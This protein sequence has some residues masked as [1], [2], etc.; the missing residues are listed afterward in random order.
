MIGNKTWL[1]I[2]VMGLVVIPSLA[3][4]ATG[5]DF[6]MDKIEGIWLTKSNQTTNQID[7]DNLNPEI[8]FEDSFANNAAGWVFSLSSINN[9]LAGFPSQYLEEGDSNTGLYISS[10]GRDFTYS[11]SVSGISHAYKTFQIPEGVD[12][13]NISF[14]WIA[15]GY[16]IFDATTSSFIQKDYMKV[17]LVPAAYTP[18]ADQ[19]ITVENSQGIHIGN[20]YYSQNEWILR[21][22]AIHV[23]LGALADQEVKIVFEWVTHGEGSGRVPVAVRQLVIHDITCR[24]VEQF[25]FL[26]NFSA[27]STTRDCWTILDANEDDFT[28]K[29]K[30]VEVYD[31]NTQTYVQ[32]TVASIETDGRNGANDDW[33]IS[34]TFRLSG[35]QRLRYSYR[36]HSSLHPNDFRVVFSTSGRDM[37]NF[38]NT[39]V[40]LTTYNNETYQEEILEL[41]GENGAMFTGDITFAWHV[42]SGGSEGWELMIRDVVVEDIPLC[43]LPEEIAVTTT[44]MD[45]AEVHW[46]TEMD[47]HEAEVAVQ[48]ANSGIPTQ[49]ER[50]THADYTANG[51]ISNTA[52]EVYIRSICM[53]NGVEIYSEWVG[54]VLFRTP[55]EPV[56]LPYVEDFEDNPIWGVSNDTTNQWVIGSAVHNGGTKALYIS[57]NQGEDNQY[58]IDLAQVSHYYKDIMIPSTAID[59]EVVLDWR[60]VG[61][62]GSDDFRIWLVPI[63]FTPEAGQRITVSN[64]R[65]IQLDRNQFYD[66]E[67]FSTVVIEREVTRYAGQTMRL[68]LEWKNNGGVGNQPPAAIDNL[69]LQ[70]T[71]C[72]KPTRVTVNQITQNTAEIAWRNA[73]D[74]E[75]Y[76]IYVT[77]NALEPNEA[78]VPTYAGVTNPYTVQNLLPNTRYYVW[79][80]SA[81]SATN[82]S[83]WIGGQNFITQ[84]IPAILP[85]EDQF[86]NEFSWSTTIEAANTWEVG[87]AVHNGGTRALYISDDEGVSYHSN[88]SESAVAHVY[89]DI[90]IPEGIEELTITYDWL[91]EGM[92]MQQV[93]ID[94]FRLIKTTLDVIPTSDEEIDTDFDGQVIGR[95][96]YT[97]SE[98]W[99]T[100]VVTV[101]VSANQGETIRLI[102][103]WINYVTDGDQLPA[104]IDNFSV[105]ASSCQSPT[106]AKAEIVRFTN[107]IRLSWVPQGN[108]TQWEVYIAYH[109]STPPTATT[110]GI[111]VEETPTYLIENVEE[112]QYFVYYVRAICRDENGENK[113]AWV[114]PISFSYFIPPVC[115]D[116]DGGVDGMPNA[117]DDRY[118][119][120]EDG[121]VKKTLRA[122]YY[123]IKK[124]NDYLVESIEY[125]SPFPFIGG[126]MVTLREDDQWSEVIDLGFDFCFY[127]ISY[128][129]VLIST[130]GTITFSIQDEIEDG[131]Y[132]PEGWSEWEFNQ[133]I[134]YPSE[135]EDA[136]F[137]NAVFGVMQDLDPRFSPEDHSVNYQIVGAF[138]CRA[139][140]FNIYHLGLYDMDYD[141]EDIEG[142]TQ[143][144][145]I[146]LYEG[147]NIIEVYVKNRPVLPDEPGRHNQGNGVI[148]IQNADGTVAHYP[149]MYPGDTINR[150]T[151]DWV[152]TNEAWRFTPKGDSSVEFTWLKDGVPFSTDEVI[153]VDITSSV[154]YTARAR[155]E[156][157]EGNELV[158]ERVFNFIKDDFDLSELTDYQVCGSVNDPGN[159]VEINL[160][161]TTEKIVALI[162]EANL[163][164]YTIEYYEDADLTQPLGE[165]IQVQRT[166]RVYVKLFNK[167]T[168]CIKTGAFNAVRIQPI[169]TSEFK[170]IEAC[171]RLELPSL[172]EGERYFTE[173]N[174]QGREY[175]AGEIYEIMGASTLYIYKKGEGDCFGQSKVDFLI[176]EPIVADV[177]ENQFI[178]CGSFIL[179]ER[180]EGNTYYTKPNGEGV[181]LAAGTEIILPMT[182]YIY[183][184]NG[185][186]QVYCFDESSFDITYEDCPIPKGF[187]PNGDGI[188]DTFDLTQHGISKIQVFNRY[189][190]EVYAHGM[191]YTNQFDGKDKSGNKLPAGTY[192]YI[193]ISHGKQ[194]TGWVQLNY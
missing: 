79:V 60:N 192:Y 29:Y 61:E 25:P 135:G 46:T 30:D 167:T 14:D 89:R 145:Q 36:V 160:V 146:I 72:V 4:S 85:F 44:Q 139:L 35:N 133:S 76:D 185:S 154:T 38:T 71:H 32:F 115:A 182:V 128:N 42:P 120:C 3:I 108:E 94:Y 31:P 68:I 137:L 99:Q 97:H 181:I 100:E 23:E 20:Q 98:G 159:S 177:I 155:Y 172:K 191:G 152:T 162:G 173:E 49:G 124:T 150:N 54:P 143:T 48:L 134:P 144:S 184:K 194:R 96:Y 131:H 55:L 57:N 126:D 47:I 7:R 193:V 118:I 170:T 169:V 180:S 15:G 64:S 91:V 8:I 153:D 21:R 187:S 6:W 190:I 127:G 136:P 179:P 125:N 151:G 95:S 189:G 107:N 147:T 74:V 73:T 163:D 130:N 117:E 178:Q 186:D 140:V 19:A 33:L 164:N 92:V 37:A 114:G 119:I 18:R 11:N 2:I 111:M 66:Q 40:P 52:Y 41:R 103:E 116:L 16:A 148:G 82:K 141:P 69:K 110:G 43:S 45:T 81:C 13:I 5:M 77:S 62:R 171:E 12:K 53:E 84:Q 156:V 104:A 121:I 58:S 105:K 176:Y 56:D 78:T 123:D 93:P 83:L 112:G 70:V 174:G 157:C 50:V 161:D 101:D 59:L 22:E 1:K 80:R 10:N 87:T 168:Q 138:P 28:W 9:W 88:T 158:I 90:V 75:Q 166:K 175:V 65:G 102:F 86:E 63:A 17:W 26:E 24:A 149:G 34:P 39:L 113:T 142:S 122:Q 51:L 165:I 27:Q 132:E 129:K 188:N 183:A 109:G 67:A 106:K